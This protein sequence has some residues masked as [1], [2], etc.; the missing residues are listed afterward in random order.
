MRTAP[1]VVK[2][3]QDTVDTDDDRRAFIF[4]IPVASEV[5]VIHAFHA[6]SRSKTDGAES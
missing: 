3:T 2:G 5:N 1:S 4:I 6:L